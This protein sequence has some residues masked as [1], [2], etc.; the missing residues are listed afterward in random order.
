MTGH[1]LAHDKKN[2]KTTREEASP[3]TSFQ[4]PTVGISDRGN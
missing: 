2:K 4:S 3:K 1:M